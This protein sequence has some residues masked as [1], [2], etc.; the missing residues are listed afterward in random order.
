M[1]RAVERVH[2]LCCH[3]L[4]WRSVRGLGTSKKKSTGSQLGWKNGIL[5]TTQMEIKLI[6]KDLQTIAYLL[7]FYSQWNLVNV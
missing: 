3:G 5:F 1:P 2:E 4:L 7:T 6:C